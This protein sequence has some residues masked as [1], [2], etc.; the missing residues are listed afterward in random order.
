MNTEQIAVLDSTAENLLV[1][2]GPGSGKTSTLVE[3]VARRCEAGDPARVLC[4]TFTVAG[5]REMRERLKARGVLK[6]GYIGTLHAFLLKLITRNHKLLKL[7]SNVAV[8]DEATVEELL[9]KVMRELGCRASLKQMMASM[10]DSEEFD[11]HLKTTT[12]IAVVELRRRLL[13]E[14]LVTLDSL[15]KLGLELIK[16]LKA[17]GTDF[18]YDHLFVDEVQDSAR[19]DFNIYAQMPVKTRFFV[20]DPDQSIFGLRGA[21]PGGIVS[22]AQSSGLGWETLMLQTNHRSG[23][24][25]CEAAQRMIER[26]ENRVNK[27]TK[28][29]KPG[30]E[31][32]IASCRDPEEELL[33]LA[34]IALKA[35]ET[36]PQ[37]TSLAVLCRT[38][39][40]AASV[41]DRL[42][43]ANFPLAEES[44]PEPGAEGLR[45]AKLLVTALVNLNSDLAWLS[46]VRAVD[47]ASVSEAIERKAK[48][49]MSSVRDV[50]KSGSVSP[51]WACKH[52]LPS[53]S[54]LFPFAVRE[55]I[56]DACRELS[57]NGE[58]ELGDLLLYMNSG[59][60]KPVSSQGIYVGTVHSAKGREWDAVIVPGLEEGHFPSLKK[61][62]DIEEERRLMFVAVTR[63]RKW[64]YLLH[65]ATRAQNRGPNLPPGPLEPRKASRFLSEISL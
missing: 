65:S 47:G 28:A 27:A 48:A 62:A 20:G 5:A 45:A 7:P 9:E 30:G 26:N 53:L 40:M 57:A 3:K 38:N 4:I 36:D 19:I 56:H 14:G 15:L 21:W 29:H 35:R 25:I 1:V 46:L 64:L 54:A 41:R 58:W 18:G 60:R 33:K 61:D 31:I 13:R 49:A 63:A 43:I 52:D 8:V 6:V 11:L 32:E 16:K 50:I 10:R 12:H 39:R 22:I 55:R 51:K 37:L 17:S 59:E 34:A 24:V 42:R 2:A 23:S 44:K